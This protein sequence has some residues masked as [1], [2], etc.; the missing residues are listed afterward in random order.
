MEKTLNL[1]PKSDAA[2]GEAVAEHLHIYTD[3]CAVCETDSRGHAMPG[4]LSSLELVVDAS[5]G[6]VPLWAEAVTLRWRFQEQALL[7]FEHVED[8]KTYVRILLGEGLLEWGDAAPVRFTEVEDAWDFEIVVMNTNKCF[9]QGCVTG[10]AF[11]PDGGRHQFRLRPHL[12]TLP[13]DRQVTVMAHELG[14]IFG[15]RHFFAELHE[16]H[17]PSETLGTHDAFSIMNYGDEGVMTENDRADLKELYRL[18]WS[19]EMTAIN[20]TP[21]RLVRPFSEGRIQNPTLDPL[22]AHQ[23]RPSGGRCCC[24]CCRCC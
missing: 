13:W 10:S 7:A 16:A 14:H 4:G 18:A 2:T 3:C 5:E 15:L 8:I 20:G 6:F 19:G 22:V 24:R 9:P 12:F 23:A 17:L 21:V 1:E 11:L